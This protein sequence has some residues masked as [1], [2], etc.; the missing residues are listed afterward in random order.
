MNTQACGCAATAWMRASVSASHPRLACE[1][2][3]PSSTVKQVL[4]NKTPRCAQA[5]KEPLMGGCKPKSAV[6]S[7]KIL[8]KE[9]GGATPDCTE[10]A[11]PSEI[12]RAHV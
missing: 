1:P 3:C 10:N 2:A 7:L 6:N 11:K 8:R 5:S 4:S 12:G 9:G